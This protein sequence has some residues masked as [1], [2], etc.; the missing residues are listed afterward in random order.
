M[1]TSSSTANLAT[2][3]VGLSAVIGLPWWAP[4]VKRVVRWLVNYV[5]WRGHRNRALDDERAVNS[6]RTG[7]ELLE[8][9]G[10]SQD[11]RNALIRVRDSA[12]RA[13][14]LSLAHCN[15][16]DG[17]FTVDEW[18]EAAAIARDIESDG[19]SEIKIYMLARLGSLL[20]DT[21]FASAL[22]IYKET[23]AAAECSNHTGRS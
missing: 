20:A 1:L 13:V 7:G 3:L 17:S 16:D 14:V 4:T 15:D 18:A 10:G 23:C 2:L 8:E 19:P 11:E 5:R 12:A 6:A 21:E 9:C 22:A